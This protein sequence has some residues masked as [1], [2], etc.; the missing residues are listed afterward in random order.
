MSTTPGKFHAD[1]HRTNTGQTPDRYRRKTLHKKKIPHS[2]RHALA[3]KPPVDTEGES[4]VIQLE[5]RRWRVV[6]IPRRVP[7]STP[8][9]TRTL[10][11]IRGHRMET[12]PVPVTF[13]SPTEPPSRWSDG[14][15]VGWR[16]ARV[17]RGVVHVSLCGGSVKSCIGITTTFCSTTRR[18][19][20][21][22]GET[23]G[24]G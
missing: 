2:K 19:T 14:R 23:R 9:V 20:V 18:R 15:R 16:S 4:A 13:H 8:H 12:I 10:C 21:T 7:Y 3:A 24:A 17:A 22:H 6:L 5:G 1:Q 11:Y